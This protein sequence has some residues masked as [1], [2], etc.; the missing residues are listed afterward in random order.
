MGDLIKEVDKKAVKDKEEFEKA[1][2]SAD[3]KEGVLFMVE[4]EG[5]TLFVVVTSVN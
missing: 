3:L 1:M 4:R 2:S 5:N